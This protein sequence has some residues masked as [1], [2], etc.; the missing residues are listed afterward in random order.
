[1]GQTHPNW[2]EK[3]QIHLKWAK[4]YHT[5]TNG[6]RKGINENDSYWAKMGQ[7]YSY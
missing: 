7:T 1:M 3:G 6:A 2:A 5:F 4:K